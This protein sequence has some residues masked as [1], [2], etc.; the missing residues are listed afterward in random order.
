MSTYILGVC[1][2]LRYWYCMF[3]H[4]SHIPEKNVKVGLFI[5]LKKRSGV[6]H[7]WPHVLPSNLRG[8]PSDWQL[9]VSGHEDTEGHRI[10]CFAT[11]RALKVVFERFT[12][13]TLQFNWHPK[14]IVYC[15]LASLPDRCSMFY[16][17]LET[18]AVAFSDFFNC[19]LFFSSMPCLP[20]YFCLAQG[21]FWNRMVK[22]V[23]ENLWV[24][25]G[26]RLAWQ[27]C[28]RLSLEQRLL[29]VF[30]LLWSNV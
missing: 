16:V 6:T 11:C 26:R 13:H 22:R 3:S 28:L 25:C 1:W 19:C 23:H 27:L 2:N 17:S 4:W 18:T 21:P 30:S 24:P 20:S 7:L 9:Y 29:K 5:C 15:P 12:L 14:Y 10:Y 8:P